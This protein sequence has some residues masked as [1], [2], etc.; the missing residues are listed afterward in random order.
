[1]SFSYAERGDTELSEQMRAS[2]S[3][4]FKSCNDAISHN[5]NSHISGGIHHQYTEKVAGEGCIMELRLVDWE[6]LKLC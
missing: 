5:A 2:C 6:A 1:M 3:Y 4:G